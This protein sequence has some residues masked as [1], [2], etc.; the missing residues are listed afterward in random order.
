MF[1]VRIDADRLD[2]EQHEKTLDE[3]NLS[4]Q[5][6]EK[7]W[8][9]SNLRGDWPQFDPQFLLDKLERDLVD[10]AEFALREDKA[11]ADVLRVRNEVGEW[12]RRNATSERGLFSLSVP[13]GGGKTLASIL[14]ALSHAA[15]HNRALAA[16]DPNCFRRVIVVIPYLSII[17]QT[18]G[19][20]IKVFGKEWV[21]EHH[22][23]AEEDPKD[24]KKEREDGRWF[25]A[26]WIETT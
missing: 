23:Q 11:S 19:E 9:S 20:L 2:A 5:N 12:C 14:F 7:K 17:E 24:Y 26:A 6:F 3:R 8:S 15:H 16:E 22:S 1:S 10:R 4:P 21:P 13:T 18:V 25:S